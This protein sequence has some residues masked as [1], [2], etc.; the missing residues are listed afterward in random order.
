MILSPIPPT[1]PLP[2][3]PCLLFRIYGVFSS[4]YFFIPFPL[5][6]PFFHLCPLILLIIFR[7][8]PSPLSVSPFLPFYVSFEGLIDE[9]LL[10]LRTLNCFG[11]FPK[12]EHFQTPRFVPATFPY[13]K[14]I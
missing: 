6:P 11:A 10:K 7:P 3:P 13:F 2:L 14:Q 8:L 12:Q 4:P 1:I 5:F 9:F